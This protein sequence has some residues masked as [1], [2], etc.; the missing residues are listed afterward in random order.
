VTIRKG[1]EWG[2]PAARPAD[3]I[4]A[5]SDA[6]LGALVAHDPAAAYSVGGGDLYR[7]VGSPAPRASMQRLPVDAMLVDLDG[8]RCLAVA[9]VVARS[10]WWT[11]RI[12]VASN[13]GYLGDWNVAP[14]AHPNDGR[15]DVL[16]VDPA[17]SVRQR[18][19]AR[20]RLRHG[21]HVPHP[22]LTARLVESAQWTFDDPLAVYVDGVRHASCSRLSVDVAPDHFS[23]YV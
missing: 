10:G 15:I 3:L 7:S 22:H 9:H 5:R 20:A 8:E 12:V 4:V 1:E 16:E 2:T 6:E 23:I 18:L 13:C 11:G 17:M 14:R 19:Q 21:T